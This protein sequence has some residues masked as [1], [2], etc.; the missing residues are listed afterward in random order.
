MLNDKIKDLF[1]NP[2]PNPKLVVASIDSFSE[3]ARQQR[4]T[5]WNPIGMQLDDTIRVHQGLL[6]QILMAYARDNDIEFVSIANQ[7]LIAPRYKSKRGPFEGDI[8]AWDVAGRFGFSSC[9]NGKGEECGQYQISGVKYFGEGHFGIWDPKSET[10]FY[11]KAFQLRTYGT[12]LDSFTLAIRKGTWRTFIEGEDF[13]K[14]HA[15]IN[16]DTRW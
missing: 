14:Q 4:D 8:F 3:Q 6:F 16:Y 15:T 10:L 9:G 7:D 12:I 2:L 5:V 13:Q 11:E 1:G